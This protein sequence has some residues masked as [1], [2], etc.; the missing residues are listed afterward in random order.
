MK[1]LFSA[2]LALCLIWAAPALSEETEGT[3]ATQASATANASVVVTQTESVVAP[4]SG[5]LLP[6]DAEVGDEVSAGETLFQMDTIKIYASQ[7][8]ELVG[9]FAEAGDDAD[10]V[11]ER[12]GALAVIEPE[13]PYYIAASTRTAYDDLANKNIHVG[14]I[15]YLKRNSDRGTGRVTSVDGEN[16]TVELLE[17]DYEITNTVS[18]FRTSGLDSDSK[19][20]SG[21]IYRYPDVTV[22]GSGR[23]LNVYVEEGDSVEAGDLLFELVDASCNP[24]N[25]TTDVSAATGGV[26]SQVLVTSGAQVYQGQVLC[27]IS[28]LSSLELSAE[29]DEIYLSQIHVGSTMEYV[30]DAYPDRQMTGEVTRIIPLGT[31]KQNATY[32]DVRISITTAGSNILPDMSGTLYIG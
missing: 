11:I 20:G 8:G 4:Y 3:E 13:N 31:A 7:S 1:K 14:E 28:D 26:I 12:Y 18:C 2:L 30:L 32:Y 29:V 9:L 5:T 15:L 25:V 22:T 24:Q 6:F 10:G 21:D 16:F 17:G 27:E 19:V 23:V